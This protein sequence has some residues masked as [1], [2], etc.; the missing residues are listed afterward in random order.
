MACND[1]IS[2][3]CIESTLDSCVDVT[4]TLGENTKIVEGCVSQKD[5]NNDLYIITDEIITNSNTSQL[6]NLC[7]S[8][9]ITSGKITLKSV[10]ETHETEICN[11]KDRL[12]NLE[13][14]NIA[15]L[16]ITGFGL[17]FNCLSDP[18]GDPITTFG[19]LLQILINKT[20]D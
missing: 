11:I 20:C 10:F 16:D 17:D 13:N 1:D 3:I 4:A 6:G 5:V 2:N 9:P 8:Y 18:C 12:N 14:Q 7:I 15:N 19:Q